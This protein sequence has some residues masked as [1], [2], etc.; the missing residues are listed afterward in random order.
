MSI[1][2]S[3]FNPR[4]NKNVRSFILT[5]EVNIPLIETMKKKKR[6]KGDAKAEQK[7]KLM[8]KNLFPEVKSVGL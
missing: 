4:N 3:H 8:P 2:R 1:P 7:R 6:K 5:L